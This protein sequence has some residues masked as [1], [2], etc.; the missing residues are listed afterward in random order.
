MDEFRAGEAQHD[1][2]VL[3]EDASTTTSPDSAAAHHTVFRSMCLVAVVALEHLGRDEAAMGH[4]LRFD[5]HLH[6]D[7]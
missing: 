3:T 5:A 4:Y 6:I 1:V 2:A 7:G